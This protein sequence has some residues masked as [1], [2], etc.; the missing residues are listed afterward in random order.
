MKRSDRVFFGIA[1]G[2]INNWKDNLVIVKPE[3]VFKWHRQGFKLLRKSKRSSGRERISFETKKLIIQLA[4]ENKSWGIPRIHGEILKL[5]FNISQ[6][7]V[8]RYLQNLRRNKPS[9]NWITFLR[10]HSN[11]IISMDFFTV[12]TINFK[13]LHVLVMIENHRRR[14]IHFNV[15]EHPT[16]I[17]SVQQMRN[18]LYNENSYKYVIRD[19]DCK[20][21][22]YFGEKIN[23]VG[24][25]EIVTAYR[26]PWQNGY[27]E[28]VI[29]T[30]RR[31]CLDHFIVFNETHLREILKEYFYYY[32]KFRT[33]L[34]LDKDTPENRPI[35]PYGEIANI[36]VLNGLHNIYFRE[37][38]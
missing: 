3:T 11:E 21:G 23:D 16:S 10:N 26:S 29:G 22:K 24:I 13:L 19:R 1:K 18:A 27:V 2:L 15:T 4:E 9:Q 33:H 25:K 5:G 32:N 36:P 12:P 31:E 14:I 17:W 35:E 38:V 6:S 20:F 37:A 30:I 8:F 34:G 7:T 28:R